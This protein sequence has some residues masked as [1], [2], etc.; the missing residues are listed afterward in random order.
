MLT[1]IKG[2]RVCMAS[3][4]TI[5]RRSFNL[6][7][8]TFLHRIPFPKQLSQFRSCLLKTS[9][10]QPLPEPFPPVIMLPSK[11]DRLMPRNKMSLWLLTVLV[12]LLCTPAE[13]KDTPVSFVTWLHRYCLHLFHFSFLRSNIECMMRLAFTHEEI[14]PVHS[15]RLGDVLHS[16]FC[17]FDQI[18]TL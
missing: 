18:S 9:E 3:L 13:A 6:L 12:A 2:E 8:F 16:S 5:Y 7:C 4:S 15:R 11:G 10:S 1:S 17:S 14:F